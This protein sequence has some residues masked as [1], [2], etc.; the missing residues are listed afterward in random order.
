MT[1]VFIT[2]LMVITFFCCNNYIH[3]TTAGKDATLKITANQIHYSKGTINNDGI[4][5]LE[6]ISR[7]GI[8]NYTLGFKTQKAATYEPMVVEG[9]TWWYDAS[10]YGPIEYGIRIGSMTLI[11]GFEWNK[12]YVC[13]LHKDVSDDKPY[14]TT[15][16]WIKY[17][18][19]EGLVAYIREEDGK[20]FAKIADH[21]FPKELEPCAL[22]DNSPLFWNS[23]SS[24]MIYDFSKN[25]EF[26]L[27]SEENVSPELRFTIIDNDIVESCG[28]SYNRLICTAEESEYLLNDNVYFTQGIGITGEWN[29]DSS[30]LYY[31]LFYAPFYMSE[32]N[33]MNLVSLKYVTDN[34]NKI[35][36][37]GTGGSKLWEQYQYDAIHDVF[38]ENQIDKVEYYNLHGIKIDNP[39]PGSIAIILKNNQ[40]NKVLFK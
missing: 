35:I 3:A 36:Y 34:E 40:Y 28:F 4:S 1:R 20:I 21:H 17:N 38:N 33:G 12:V 14:D 15:Y 6:V 37:Q 10:W 39:I 31:S 9:R 29:D 24:A 11:D 30:N 8:E 27:G 25:K 7:S 23:T 18:E 22:L 16:E 5:H 19:D 13:L 32:T 2:A 26:K